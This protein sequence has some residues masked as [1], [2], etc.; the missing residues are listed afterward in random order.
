[1]RVAVEQR[2]C[3]HWN[4]ESRVEMKLEI[5]RVGKE[6]NGCIEFCDFELCRKTNFGTS[7][8]AGNFDNE[9]EPRSVLPIEVDC[10]QLK[11]I[12]DQ[13]R[14]VPTRTIALE[15]DVC[16]KTIV[17]ALK[18]I[19]LTFQFNRCVPHELT[20]ED[21]RKRKATC[22]ALLRDQRKRKLW[23]ELG[24]VMKNGCTTTIQAVKEGGQHL[25]NQ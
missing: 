11:Q 10:E 17:N 21:K 9:D 23:T 24:P 5:S 25:G 2:I 3:L 16:R 18:R 19:N 22:L 13:D 4:R 20:A 6:K 7:F 14:N 15:L 1:M 12:I 8:K